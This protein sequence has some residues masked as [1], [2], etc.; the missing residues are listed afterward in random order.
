MRTRLRNFGV[1]AGLAGALAFGGLAPA[2]AAS[3]PTSTSVVK[4]SQPDHVDQVYW[5]GRWGGGWGAGPFVAGAAIGLIGATAAYGAWGYPGYGYGYGA[6]YYASYGYGAPY[7]YYGAPYYRRYAYAGYPSY[8][9]PRRYW[10]PRRVYG[11]RYVR[12]GRRW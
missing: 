5:R 4:A 7:G 10:G 6:P 12:Y 1:A 8:Y 11:H 2:T 9:G 3:V